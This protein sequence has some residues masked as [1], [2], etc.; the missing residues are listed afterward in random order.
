MK[1]IK[2]KLKDLDEKLIVYEN[3]SDCNLGEFVR[4]EIEEYPSMIVIHQVL[5]SYMDGDYTK[6]LTRLYESYNSSRDFYPVFYYAIARLMYH[7]IMFL[8]NLPV[9][10]FN[11]F[12]EKDRIEREINNIHLLSSILKD[13]KNYS[14]LLDQIWI[15][16]NNISII[17]LINLAKEYETTNWEITETRQELFEILTNRLQK[18]EL[19]YKRKKYKEIREIGYEIHNLP[20]MLCKDIIFPHNFK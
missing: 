20:E 7:S 12:I 5:L 13:N 6:T 18:I 4:V 17:P 1:T 3:L 14:D 9:K 8:R 10:R 2:S 15:D 19:L 11:R 16:D